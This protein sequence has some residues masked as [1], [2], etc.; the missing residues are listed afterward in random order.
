MDKST[1]KNKYS[2]IVILLLVVCLGYTGYLISS[3]NK[4]NYDISKELSNLLME[5]NEM[6]KILLNEEALSASKALNLKDNLKL[7]LVSYDSIELSNTIVIDSINQQRVKIKTLIDKVD[8][9]NS[10]SK[11]DWKSIFKLKKE[12]E[13]L[14]GIMIGYI[15][16][17]DSLNTLNV[18]LSNNLTEKTN[19]LKTVSNLNKRYKKQNKDLESKVA[20]GAVLQAGNITVSAI[21]I[22]NSGAQSETTRAAK[23]N[24]IKACFNLL[25]NK[26]SKSGDKNIYI[27]VVDPNQKILL[28]KNPINIMSSDGDNL[29]LSSK[30]I[31]NYQNENMDLCIFHEIKDVLN[32]G[33][34]KV[35]I[36]NDGYFIGESSFAL[37]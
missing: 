14:R 37:R 31:V 20:L 3:L 15:H 36:Y 18:N 4:E 26:L 6:N 1:T 25:E 5:N 27:K 33:N 17:I 16:T 10:K 29:E 7:L 9:L 30:R 32:P 2:S 28:S 23:T 22:R 21:R 13:T 8:K 24:T 34:Y 12:A 35:E 11:K 19:K